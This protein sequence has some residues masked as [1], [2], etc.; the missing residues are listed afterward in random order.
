MQCKRRVQVP[1]HSG[2]I[3]EITVV[4]NLLI[5]T[6]SMATVEEANEAYETI[7]GGHLA[8]AHIEYRSMLGA[9]LRQLRKAAGLTQRQAAERLGVDENTVARW[10][11]GERGISRIT[12][13]AIRNQLRPGRQKDRE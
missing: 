2:T 4:D 1:D 11:R 7:G 3:T 5:V 12:E 8:E 6:I 13:L 9:D 10:E